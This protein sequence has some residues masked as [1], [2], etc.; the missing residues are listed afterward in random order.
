M[1][2]PIPAL[3]L[4]LAFTLAVAALAP[5]QVAHARATDGTITPLAGTAPGFAGDGGPATQAQLDTPRDVAVLADGSVVIADF[6]ND[7]VR[8]VEPDGTMTTAAGS[9]RGL[10]GDAGPAQDA[11]LNRPRGVTSLADGGYLIADTFNHE[12]RRVRPDGTIVAVAGS[13]VGG[14]AGDGGPATAARL[15]LPSD[16]ATLPGGGF[17][18]ADTGNDRVRRVAPDG[19][20]TTIAGSTRG[21]SGDGG[22]ATAAQLSEPRDIAV[23]A[24][25]GILIADTGNDRV[26]RV[27]PDGTITTVA[28]VGAGLAGDGDPARAARLTAPFSVAT[29][30]NGGILVADTG[31]DRV[32]RITPLGAIFTVAGTTAGLSGDGALAKGAQLSRPG[33]VTLAPGGGFIVADSGNARVRRVSDVGAVPPAVT[34]R[35][36]ALEPGFGAVRVSPL[37]GPAGQPL[38]EEDLVPVASSVDATDGGLNVTTTGDERG[39]QQTARVY[40]GAFTLTQIGTAQGPVTRFRLPSLTGC[41]NEPEPRPRAAR[42]RSPARA[43][44]AA[45]KTKRSRR[46]WVKEKGGRWRTETGSVSAAAV[47]T[48]WLTTMQCDGTRVTVTEGQVLVRDKLRGRQRLLSAGQSVK[49]LTR[50]RRRGL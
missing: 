44:I 47:G 33:A 6:A 17:L 11:E 50:G 12:I 10:S 2:T 19:T 1:T 36:F 28:G 29:L 22:P 38:K 45:K 49:V 41:R 35:S 4:L 30:P 32:R 7:R 16:T 3:R 18:I 39:T 8:R 21:F 14:P 31:N 9:T 42:S 43:S 25:G 46:L 13:G 5:A 48:G 37:G 27:A 26:R 34:G 20:I 23:A 40:Q 24:D 15:N